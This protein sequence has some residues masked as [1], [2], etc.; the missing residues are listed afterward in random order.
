MQNNLLCPP[1]EH[2]L[3]HCASLP[4]KGDFVR[5]IFRKNCGLSQS[6]TPPTNITTSPV[7]ARAPAARCGRHVAKLAHKRP[8]F[9][10]GWPTLD[11]IRNT[12]GPSL[13]QIGPNP[14]N[15]GQHWSRFGRIWQPAREN[16]PKA[17][18]GSMFRGTS[19]YFT[20]AGYFTGACPRTGAPESILRACGRHSIRAGHVQWPMGQPRGSHASSRAEKTLVVQGRGEKGKAL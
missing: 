13:G 17:P 15:F 2:I 10:R 11:K 4:E 7:S 5:Q 16:Y 12:S 19:G 14:V 8:T 3:H 9:D 6:W 1:A 20:S 18:P